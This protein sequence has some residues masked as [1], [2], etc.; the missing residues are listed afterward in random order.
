LAA[1]E[2][3]PP[4][5]NQRKIICIMVVLLLPGAFQ[6]GGE[7][8]RRPYRAQEKIDFLRCG[9]ATPQKI[10]QRKTFVS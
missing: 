8:L 3:P 2:V 5:I 9:C 6:N 4:K 10:N 1:G 7:N